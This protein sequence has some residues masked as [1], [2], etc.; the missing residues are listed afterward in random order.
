MGPWLAAI[1]W[2]TFARLLRGMLNSFGSFFD[3]LHH[4][5]RNTGSALVIRRDSLSTNSC[6]PTGICLNFSYLSAC[7]RE[8]ASVGANSPARR[9]TI[10]KS[11]ENSSR[12]VTSKSWAMRCSLG[13]RRAAQLI[14]RDNH[15]TRS[16]TDQFQHTRGDARN[17]VMADLRLGEIDGRGLV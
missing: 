17:L 3:Q 1:R 2:F 9:V 10:S 4:A 15:L 13:V 6:G 12:I 8:A 11:S 5:G 7:A 14:T 16:L